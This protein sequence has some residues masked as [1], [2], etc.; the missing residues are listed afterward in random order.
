M[1]PTRKHR[2][3]THADFGIDVPVVQLLVQDQENCIWK[4]RQKRILGSHRAYQPSATTI[5]EGTKR[6]FAHLTSCQASAERVARVN[7]GD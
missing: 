7:K 5:K 4:R 1:Q 2:A 3:N 6:H